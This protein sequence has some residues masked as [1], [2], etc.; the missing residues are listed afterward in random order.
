MSLG[1]ILEPLAGIVAVIGTYLA[2]SL[3]WPAVVCAALVL[4]YLAQRSHYSPWLAH[5]QS[6][7][8]KPGDALVARIP[9]RLSRDEYEATQQRLQRNFPGVRVIVIPDTMELAKVDQQ[10]LRASQQASQ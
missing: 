10:A 2:T 1:A 5:L 7:R 3:A 6:L 9:A 8:L 4:A